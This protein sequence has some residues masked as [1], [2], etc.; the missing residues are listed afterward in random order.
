[1]IALLKDTAVT[2]G[3]PYREMLSQA[4]H[5]A[6]AL[7]DVTPAAM[8]FTPCREGIS[9]N[10][11]EEIDHSRTLAGANLLLHAVLRRANR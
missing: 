10:T 7:A 6:Y 5:D 2:L 11:N 4:G 8:I 1:M 9:H 3:L